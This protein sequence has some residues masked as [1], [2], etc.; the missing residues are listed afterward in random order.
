MPRAPVHTD[1][2]RVPAADIETADDSGYSIYTVVIGQACEFDLFN[3]LPYEPTGA[4]WLQR[5]DLSGTESRLV[6]LLGDVGP[7]PHSGTRASF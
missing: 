5:K 7:R 4:I 3:D 1:D 2:R 6:P